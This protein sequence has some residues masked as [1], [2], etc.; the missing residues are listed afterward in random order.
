MLPPD[1][2][3]GPAGRSG[4]ASVFPDRSVRAEELYS[5]KYVHNSILISP[6]SEKNATVISLTEQWVP[7]RV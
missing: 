7:A 3:P 4:H 6:L 5:W 2:G 1:S